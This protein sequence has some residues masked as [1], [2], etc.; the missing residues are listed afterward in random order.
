MPFDDVGHMT[1][2][3]RVYESSFS[4]T[5]KM[6]NGWQRDEQYKDFIPDQEDIEETIVKQGFTIYPKGNPITNTYA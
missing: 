3:E 5:S 1:E 2:R 6:K 4:M